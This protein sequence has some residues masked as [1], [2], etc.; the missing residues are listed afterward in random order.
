MSFL[1]RLANLKDKKNIQV[2]LDKYWKKDHILSLSDKLFDY[3]YKN[4]IS[5]KYNFLISI[6]DKTNNINGLLGFIEAK[7]YDP[8]YQTQEMFYGIHY[9]R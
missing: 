7:H 4:E 3:M 9:G 2:F 6:D 5:K 1:I 8:F